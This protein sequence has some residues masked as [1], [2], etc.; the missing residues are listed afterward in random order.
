MRPGWGDE[1]NSSM[2]PKQNMLQN[3]KYAL[4]SAGFPI[5][6]IHKVLQLDKKKISPLAFDICVWLQ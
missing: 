2:R 3:A 4:V 1:Q 6:T 5:F